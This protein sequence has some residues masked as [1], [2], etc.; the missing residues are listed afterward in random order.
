FW[1]N[2]LRS[3]FAIRGFPSGLALAREGEAP[4]AVAFCTEGGIQR[5]HH[6]E[7]PVI[8]GRHAIID[9]AQGVRKDGAAQGA[10]LRV[11]KKLFQC[12]QYRLAIR[13]FRRIPGDH[14]FYRG[15]LDRR[16]VRPEMWWK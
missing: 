14:L 7:D 2:A 6:V 13:C 5:E 8:F 4:V 1:R 12:R 3:D 11:W 16:I 15:P 9:P 10:H